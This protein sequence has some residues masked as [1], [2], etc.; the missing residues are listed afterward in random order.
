MRIDH[1]RCG[2]KVDQET[3][4]VTT[5][6]TVQ[7]NL[8]IFTHSTRRYLQKYLCKKIQI[9]FK[10]ILR[11]LRFVVVCSYQ[12]DTL[13]V[14]ASFAVPGQGSAAAMEPD[15]TQSDRSGRQRKFRMV[16]KDSLV[17]RDSAEAVLSDVKEK[18]VGGDTSSLSQR[19]A[20]KR[21]DRVDDA[22]IGENLIDNEPARLSKFARLTN[23]RDN[24]QGE[25]TV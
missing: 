18:P 2:S 14:R 6:I 21:L 23:N 13:T 7:E 12:P 24:A 17:V 1:T 3:L 5:Y 4:T 9:N 19:Q 15:W 10:S 20:R 25:N 8:G 22:D 16:G 11:I